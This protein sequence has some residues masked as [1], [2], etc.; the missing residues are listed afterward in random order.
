MC[1]MWWAKWEGWGEWKW[2][3]IEAAPPP[4]EGEAGTAGSGSS[5]RRTH[6][7]M[8]RLSVLTVP[9]TLLA[10]A[11]PPTGG[12]DVGEAWSDESSGLPRDRLVIPS[13]MLTMRRRLWWNDS[14]SLAFFQTPFGMHLLK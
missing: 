4:P 3:G 2:K 6:S 12:S 11:G 7:A 1:C 14:L 8:R 10:L 5:T 9:R 13:S